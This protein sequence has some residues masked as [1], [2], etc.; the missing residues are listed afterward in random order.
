[1]E[2]TVQDMGVF[3]MGGSTPG[4]GAQKERTHGLWG[5]SREAGAGVAKRGVGE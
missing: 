1:M 3:R 5:R 2:F 4:G